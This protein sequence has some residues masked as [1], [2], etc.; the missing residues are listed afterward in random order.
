MVFSSPDRNP[1]LTI[2]MSTALKHAGLPPLDP[3]LPGGLLSL[4]QPG[5]IE[6][7]QAGVGGR[8]QKTAA[9]RRAQPHA[10][11]AGGC[12]HVATLVERATHATDFFALRV[13]AAHARKAWS[14]KSAPPKLPDFNAR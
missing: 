14:K 4:G 3:A 9:L 1:C 7:A 8:D 5:R 6:L 12:V 11:V 10:D 13:E 2:L